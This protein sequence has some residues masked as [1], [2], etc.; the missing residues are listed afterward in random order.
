MQPGHDFGQL[1]VRVGSV[2]QKVAELRK[3]QSLLW[4]VKSLDDRSIGGSPGTGRLSAATEAVSPHK[5]P[6]LK[7]SSK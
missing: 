5:A 1:S 4:K 7:P 3:G 6:D 2:I